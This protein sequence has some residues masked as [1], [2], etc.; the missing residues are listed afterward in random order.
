MNGFMTS[1]LG[2]TAAQQTRADGWISQYGGGKDCGKL[3]T[4]SDTYRR[5]SNKTDKSSSTRIQAGEMADLL[6]A[7]YT[8]CMSV[9]GAVVGSPGAPSAVAPAGISA[10]QVVST[11]AQDKTIRY[12]LY[13][14]LVLALAVGGVWAYK[15]YGKGK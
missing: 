12:L 7:A 15:R 4:L 5:L 1:G 2:L 3:A 14:G 9:T 8:Q 10:P 13:G 6:G 11:P